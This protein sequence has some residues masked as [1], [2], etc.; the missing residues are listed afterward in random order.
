M[1]CLYACVT[2]STAFSPTDPMPLSSRAKLLMTVES[3]SGLLTSLLV[4]ARAG[5]V[6]R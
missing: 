2:N 3:V 5:S 4:I 1:D 6:L